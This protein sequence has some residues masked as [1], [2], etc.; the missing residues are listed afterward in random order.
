MLPGRLVL[1]FQADMVLSDNGTE[2]GIVE[3]SAGGMIVERAFR[4]LFGHDGRLSLYD[5]GIL[6]N[7]G[8]LYPNGSRITMRF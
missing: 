1:F 2:F 7:A 3:L 5:L 8:Q 6:E 4:V